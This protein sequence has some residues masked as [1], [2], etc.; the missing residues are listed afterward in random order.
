M[1]AGG[2]ISGGKNSFSDGHQFGR[3]EGAVQLAQG[4]HFGRMETLRAQS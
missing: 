3:G 2:G 4:T 1:G